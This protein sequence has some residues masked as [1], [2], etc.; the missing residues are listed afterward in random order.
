MFKSPRCGSHA[1]VK[2]VLPAPWSTNEW[3]GAG[4]AK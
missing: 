4:V 1:S 2:T 3:D